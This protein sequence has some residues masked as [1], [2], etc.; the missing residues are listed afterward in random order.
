MRW[1]VLILLGVFFVSLAGAAIPSDCEGSMVAYWKF[2]DNVL[3]SYDSYDGGWTGAADYGSLMVGSAANFSGGETITVSGVP[4]SVFERAFTTEMWV[5]AGNISASLFRKENY[6]IEWVDAGANTGLVNVTIGEVSINSGVLDS[7]VPHHIAVVW[8]SSGT[9]LRLYVDGAEEDS[10]SLGS[11]EGDVDGDLVIGEGFVGL[12][13]ELAIYGTALPFYGDLSESVIDS[14]YNL[15]V[16]G[17]D[18]CD[19]SGSSTE[20]AFIINGCSFDKDD[21]GI[22][23]VSK[24][25]CAVVSG[26]EA[27]YCGIDQEGPLNGGWDVMEEGLGC[28]KGD[29]D[30]RTD[31]NKIIC[32]PSGSDIVYFCND[33]R[34]DEKIFTCDRMME[35]CVDQDDAGSC[36]GIGCLWL[37]Q[38]DECVP[39]TSE[40]RDCGYYK[41]NDSCIIDEWDLGRVGI[42]TERCGTTFECMGKTWGIPEYGCECNWYPS[43]PDGKKCQLKQLAVETEYAYGN[44]DNQNQFEWH[45]V[46][47]FE[48]CTDGKQDFK[49]FSTVN[50][51]NGPIT[52]LSGED[53]DAAYES[54]CDEIGCNGGDET[55][56]CGEPLIKLPGFSLFAF[57]M[58]LFVIGIYYFV[59]ESN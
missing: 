17:N 39:P 27:Y 2:D 26:T 50:L 20:A 46:Y 47:E 6:E 31:S 49:W 21:G 18:Y 48:N 3:D 32:C 33:S 29:V 25:A 9:M 52:E 38:T 53:F 51:I 23:G 56:S 8:D 5:S 15:G 43:G 35:N 44:N 54:C 1:G 28:A 16:G 13:D 41:D 10:D 34:S 11:T 12:I 24:G 40:D 55:R 58:S 4:T 45:N 57:F 22:I 36:T 37:D 14:H 19:S 59:K 30:Y 42:G 7:L